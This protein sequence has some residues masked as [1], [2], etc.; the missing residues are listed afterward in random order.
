[1]VEEPVTTGRVPAVALVGRPNVGKSSLLNA[2]ARR[3]ISIVEPTAGVTRDRVSA[4]VEWPEDGDRPAGTIELVDMG[5]IGVV[6]SDQLERQVEDQIR[7]ALVQCDLILFVVDVRMGLTHQDE[8]IGR[9]LHRRGARVIL[10]ANKADTVTLEAGAV[11]FVR[12]GFGDAFPVSAEQREGLADLLDLIAEALPSAPS[13][14]SSPLLSVAV[15]GRRN[16]G[17]ST[18]VNT[19]ARAERVIVSEIPGTTRDSVDVRVDIE[20]ESFLIIDTAGLRKKKSVQDSI[21]FYGQVRSEES[22]RRADAVILLLDA[23]REISQVD[24]KISALV[25]D[26]FKPC[27]I[28]LNKFDLV[29]DRD[30][31]D[32][33]DFVRQELSGLWFAPISAL[34]AKEG[35]NVLETIRLAR[36]LFE[37]AGAR[38]AT[39]ELNRALRDAIERRQPP[40]WRGRTPKIYYA[41]QVDTRPPKIVLF[42]SDPGAFTRAY[43]RYI[44]NQLRDRFAFHEVPVKIM[45][46]KSRGREEF[47]R[48]G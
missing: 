43:L 27:L 21:E 25:R 33:E 38:V 29:G 36:E 23:T 20:G 19:L 24:K 41:T 42:V 34:S 31:V 11:D 35:T 5:G 12:L 18:L 40:R 48:K 22:I 45:V 13:Q 47:E 39:P 15:V 14:A 30:A 9:E 32:F 1:M 10:V 37:Q 8:E 26:S 44:E 4:I 6:D 16:S 3:R 46:R 2:L 28:A 17:K 7:A